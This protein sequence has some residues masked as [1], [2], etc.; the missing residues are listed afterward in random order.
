MKITC[1]EATT[2]CDKNQYSEAGLLEKIKLMFHIVLCKKCGRYSKHNTVMT[3]CYN[4]YKQENKIENCCLKDAEKKA[5]ENK[6][7]A[8]V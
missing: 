4:R 5:M 6:I 2:I 7:K 3:K 1:D 8:K